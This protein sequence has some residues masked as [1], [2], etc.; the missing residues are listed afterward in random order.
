MLNHCGNTMA[1]QTL[2]RDTSEEI[3]TDAFRADGMTSSEGVDCSSPSLPVPRAAEGG[4]RR[5][6]NRR[7]QQWSAD[8]RPNISDD[9]FEDV[10]GQLAAYEEP[11]RTPSTSGVPSSVKDDAAPMGAWEPAVVEGTHGSI[12][13]FAHSLGLEYTCHPGD[14]QGC[15]CAPNSGSA[16][17]SSDD[18][19]HSGEDGC[20]AQAVLDARGTLAPSGE[21]W[22]GGPMENSQMQSIE[23]MLLCLRRRIGELHGMIASVTHVSGQQVDLDA[24][25]AG[26]RMVTG[27][28]ETMG[29]KAV[30]TRRA[31]TPTDSRDQGHNGDNL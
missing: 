16:L 22:Q 25:G 14:T 13:T 26:A 6:S 21:T 15:D 2:P 19:A 11:T 7:C 28:D 23:D 17:G 30:G 4:R 12:A 29:D 5:K 8:P 18:G 3:E 27:A 1:S 24:V 20:E 9:L 10:V 31:G